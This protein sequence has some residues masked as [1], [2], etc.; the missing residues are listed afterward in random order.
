M[1]NYQCVLNG[2]DIVRGVPTISEV[3]LEMGVTVDLDAALTVTRA[4]LRGDTRHD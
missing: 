1:S 3:L 2:E 4:E